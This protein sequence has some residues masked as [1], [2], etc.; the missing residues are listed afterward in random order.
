MFLTFAINWEKITY[1]LILR[2]ILSSFT[3]RPNRIAFELVSINSYFFTVRVKFKCFILHLSF[4]FQSSPYLIAE[5]ITGVQA[6]FLPAAVKVQGLE[7]SRLVLNIEQQ[8]H[9]A[10]RTKTILLFTPVE[11]VENW[12][13]DQDTFRH[14]CLRSKAI[15]ELI[16][17]NWQGTCLYNSIIL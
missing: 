13:I 10:L 16:S 9:I 14:T 4:L 17:I 7:K 3:D 12:K 6:V 8:Y 5:Y 15:I 11:S 2:K 1:I